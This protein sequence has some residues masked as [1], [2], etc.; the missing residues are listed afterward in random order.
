MEIFTL[1]ETLEDILENSRSLPFT[2]KSM[3]DKE[4]MLEIIKEIRIKLTD[5]LKQAYV[6]AIK[7]TTAAII[8]MI[9]A[10]LYILIIQ[11]TNP[12]GNKIGQKF[13]CIKI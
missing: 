3:V 9:P 2:S 7:P 11:A 5:E 6:I 12:N 10:G 4:E 1:L 8:G 13:I